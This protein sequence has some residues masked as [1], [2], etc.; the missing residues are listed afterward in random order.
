[1]DR[2]PSLPPR[3]SQWGEPFLK[4]PTACRGGIRPELFPDHPVRDL[5]EPLLRSG[6]DRRAGGRV[7]PAAVSPDGATGF[8]HYRREVESPSDEVPG[9]PRAH[10]DP[11]IGLRER[12]DGQVLRRALLIQG[13]ARGDAD[14]GVPDS[15]ASR[16]GLPAGSR[17]SVYV[18]P[19]SRST[20]LIPHPR[21]SMCDASAEMTRRFSPRSRSDQ[22]RQCSSVL[23]SIPS[24]RRNAMH[25]SSLPLRRGIHGSVAYCNILYAGR[26]S[27]PKSRKSISAA[28]TPAAMPSSRIVRLYPESRRNSWSWT[29]PTAPTIAIAA[30]SAFFGSRAFA[31]AYAQPA[32]LATSEPSP[33]R[34]GFNISTRSCDS[35]NRIRSPR[36]ARGTSR[37]V[38]TW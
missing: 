35:A 38:G 8:L 12:D 6:R 4:V 18:S 14:D 28:T 9:R 2:P 27:R 13:E 24:S 5:E 36:S 1:M 37:A 21:S 31:T 29:S 22:L 34:C 15:F 25:A 20:S 23:R 10:L 33:S 19:T 7:V 16:F 32:P 26:V 11:V 30:R 17:T 3:T